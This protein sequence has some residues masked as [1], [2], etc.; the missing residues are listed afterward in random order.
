MLQSR[1]AA[2]NFPKATTDQRVYA[3]SAHE[4]GTL[5]NVAI[6]GQDRTTEIATVNIGPGNEPIY[7]ITSSYTP[8]IWKVTGHPERVARVHASAGGGV[9]V[10]GVPKE[11]VSLRS[12]GGCVNLSE[13]YNGKN[14]V[15]YFTVMGNAVGKPFDGVALPYTAGYVKIPDDMHSVSKDW[16]RQN[17]PPL[18]FTLDGLPP[19]E[20]V[21]KPS[22]TLKSL[23][24]FSPGGIMAID[25]SAI[26]ASG[27]AESYSVLP[28]EAGLLQLVQNGTLEESRGGYVVKK[29]FGAF[30]AGLNGGHSV[31]FR[32]PE[33][34]RRPTNRPGHS[35]VLT[36]KGAQ[37]P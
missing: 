35:T 15:E 37:Q 17:L 27:K 8:M 14:Q 29:S 21:E 19:Q 25:P 6:A 32:F 22:E 23:K 30:P 11:R 31:T 13:K 1:A 3:I 34:M 10:I 4:A 7:L 24:R 33:G 36:L 5:S 28:Q 12:E 16:T 2:C 20:A 18:V 26:V 9:G